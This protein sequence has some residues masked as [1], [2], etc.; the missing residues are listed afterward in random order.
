MLISE[1][2]SLE[3]DENGMGNI[4]SKSGVGEKINYGEGT[5]GPNALTSIQ[6]VETTYNPWPQTIGYT[7]FNKLSYMTDTITGGDSIQLSISYGFDNQRRKSTLTQPNAGDKTKY[8][9]GDYEIITDDNSKNFP[10]EQI[11]LPLQ[12]AY[13]MRYKS[14]QGD[15]LGWMKLGFQPAESI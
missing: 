13:G 7:D 6:H 10:K 15:A 11:K 14:A 12:G 8:F 5:A 3:Y 2:L 4:I 1:N 9:F